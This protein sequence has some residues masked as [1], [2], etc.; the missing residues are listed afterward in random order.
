MSFE[1]SE[2]TAEDLKS[3]KKDP[4]ETIEKNGVVITKEE[5]KNITEDT[6]WWREPE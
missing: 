6:D 1:Q 4:N 5:L 2:K 3:L